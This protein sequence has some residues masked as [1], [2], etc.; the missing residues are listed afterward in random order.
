MKIL[1]IIPSLHS[2]GAEKFVIDL[3]NE[4]AKTNEVIICSLF[5]IEENM[6][7]VKQIDKNIKVITLNKRLGLDLQIFIKI[8]KLIQEEQPDVVNTHLR[9][10][11]YSS[12]AIF[13]F[14]IKFF[15]TVHNIASK[16]TG[17]IYRFIYKILFKKFN[18]TPIAISKIVLDSI[19]KVYSNKFNILIENGVVK[20]GESQK[21]LYV[22]KEIESLKSTKNTKVFIN[23]GR[24]TEQ[25]NQIVLIRAFNKLI[26]NGYDII[27]L[28]I[29]ED[30]D[31]EKKLLNKLKDVASN[32]VYFLGQRENVIDYLICSDAFC[33][34]SLY[35]GL[36]ITLL[37]TLSVGTIPICTPAG[38]VVDVIDKDH[39]FLSSGF[40]DTEYYKVMKQF[41]SLN[42]NSIY[43]M[44]E[45]CKQLFIEYYNIQKTAKT[46]FE[47]YKNH[48]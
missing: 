39:G 4:L 33:L 14:K 41:L 35:E 5:S 40:T 32:K 25:K 30:S 17:K 7:M 1:Q 3:S 9:A 37:E 38:G 47:L 44:E 29:G 10:L 8:Y 48:S 24:I 15:H 23:I 31:V 13:K 34:S 42:N 46:Y 12:Y 19:Q 27:L 11:F 2:A 18:V 36:P 6:F 21:I 45:N 26:E 16:E 28:I 22:K 43:E 20:L